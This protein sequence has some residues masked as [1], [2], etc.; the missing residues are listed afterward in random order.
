MAALA[1]NANESAIDDTEPK[2]S[3]PAQTSTA[4]SSAHKE[5]A[6]GLGRKLSQ[7]ARAIM[8]NGNRLRG[9]SVTQPTTTQPGRSLSIGSTTSTIDSSNPVTPSL[10]QD[11]FIT[12]GAKQIKRKMSPTGERMLRGELAF[13]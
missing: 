11:A 1:N 13:H 6:V 5:D 9:E 3:P 2:G 12:D 7:G 8:Y 4:P 10:Q